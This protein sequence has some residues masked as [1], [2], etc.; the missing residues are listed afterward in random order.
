MEYFEWVVNVIH[1][2]L[3]STIKYST[4][5][6]FSVSI[7]LKQSLTLDFVGSTIHKAKSTSLTVEINGHPTP[8]GHL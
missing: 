1:A 7:N 6:K 5:K 2:L 3:F 4:L 8:G